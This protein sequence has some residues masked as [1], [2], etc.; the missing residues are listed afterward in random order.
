[1]MISNKYCWAIV[2]QAQSIICHEKLCLYLKNLLP[3]KIFKLSFKIKM[4]NTIKD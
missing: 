3:I 2:T 1:M 4:N